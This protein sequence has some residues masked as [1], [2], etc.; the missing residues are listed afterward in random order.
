MRE[1]PEPPGEALPLRRSE[2]ALIFAFWTFIAIASSVNAM[3]DPRG[4]GL[5]PVL[6]SAPIAL[7]FIESYLWALVTPLIFVLVSRYGIERSNRAARV[8]FFLG[9][10]VGVAILVDHIV[11][12]LRFDVLFVPRRPR[13]PDFGPFVRIRR[14]W[15]MNEFIVYV[16]VL[17][18]AFAR[19]FF[20][21]YRARR[22]EAMR[23][24]EK[25]ARLQMQLADARL[26]ALRMQL[27]PHFLF[28]TLH[29][30]SALVE[31]DPKGVRRMIA[32]LSELLRTTLETQDPEVTLAHETAFLQRYVDIMQIR[33]QGR[34]EVSMRIAPEV[35]AA[36][37]PN[38]I[39]Q[40]LVENAI[41]HGVEKLEGGRIDIEARR[42]G[43]R[44]HISVRD[45]GPG[46]GEDAEATATGLGLR[47]TRARLEQLYG[48]EQELSM[49][50][51]ERGFAVEVRLPYHTRDDLRTSGV[52][53]GT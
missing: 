6:P 14:A 11:G 24:Q 15:F 32:R 47:N 12:Y 30:V 19:D 45:N 10:G 27:D 4:R 48:T 26:D 3:T 5:M 40:P 34:L 46:A 7:A 36:L 1:R 33:F 38:L 43:E 20:I 31:R 28:N 22:E 37:V 23:L 44:L 21:R 51:D 18:T 39:L 9:V 53:A 16:A 29:A 8:V 49:H 35:E 41:R 17:A 42:E 2:L 13:P 50:R 25:T 52:A